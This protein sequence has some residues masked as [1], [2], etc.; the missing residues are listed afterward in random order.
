MADLTLNDTDLTLNDTDLTLDD[1]NL[2]NIDFVGN[3]TLDLPKPTSVWN[4]VKE[5][6]WLILALVVILYLMLRRK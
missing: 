5:Y 2:G 1:I 4:G 3:L 6:W